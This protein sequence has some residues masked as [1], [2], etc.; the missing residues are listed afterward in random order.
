M[1]SKIYKENIC[2][3]D[4][5]NTKVATKFS[6]VEIE[7]FR[8]TEKN[9]CGKLVTKIKRRG[10]LGVD[11]LR[12]YDVFLDIIKSF[13]SY[14]GR[15]NAPLGDGFQYNTSL[16]SYQLVMSLAISRHSS[17]D[18]ILAD[19][20]IS[21]E[22][23]DAAKLVDQ[24]VLRGLKIID[25]GCGRSPTYANCVYHLGGNIFTADYNAPN[26]I[27]FVTK[28]ME[29]KHIQIDLDSQEAVKTLLKRTDGNFDFVTAATVLTTTKDPRALKAP[30]DARLEDI[31]L[32]LLKVNGLYYEPMYVTPKRKVEL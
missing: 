8:E 31:A 6:L 9:L 32:V 19:S 12:R 3:A 25:L 20:S 7:D 28:E 21:P 24:K 27:A 16:A 2:L 23:F 18:E 1:N 4:I 22:N 11:F 5:M 13:Q 14:T 17:I 30:S 10:Y 29:D 26:Q 15:V